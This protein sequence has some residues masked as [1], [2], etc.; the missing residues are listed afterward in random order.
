MLN[1]ITANKFVWTAC[2]Q[3]YELKSILIELE[4]TENEHENKSK[5]NVDEM[6]ARWCA[7]KTLSR[8]RLAIHLARKESANIELDFWFYLLANDCVPTMEFYVE[9]PCWRR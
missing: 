2:I 5:R 7:I 9:L 6:C 3:K 8:T 4:S 1:Q